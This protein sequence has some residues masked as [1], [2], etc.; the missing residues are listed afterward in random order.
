M[1]R[2][3]VTLR[4]VMK[5]EADW[6]EKERRVAATAGHVDCRQA[7]FG[8]QVGCEGTRENLTVTVVG[9]AEVV[10]LPIC[11]SV[12][13]VHK[14]RTFKATTPTSLSKLS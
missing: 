7:V 9:C 2:T 12:P 8:C 10:V 1:L 14:Y 3:L 4:R 11:L 6:R 5:C 13:K